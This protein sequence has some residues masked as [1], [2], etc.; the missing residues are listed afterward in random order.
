M[1]GVQMGC[2]FHLLLQKLRFP[3]DVS[4]L[5]DQEPGPMFY[6]S[7]FPPKKL[8]PNFRTILIRKNTQV[9]IKILNT[10]KTE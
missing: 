5:Y 4:S 6:N 9:A 7:N 10:A 3:L 1:M 8:D 2:A